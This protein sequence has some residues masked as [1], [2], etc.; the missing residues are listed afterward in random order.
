MI[1]NPTP[2]TPR[3]ARMIAALF[4]GMALF[5]AL[6]AAAADQ[7]PVRVQMTEEGPVFAT[8]SGMTL[9]SGYIDVGA[10]GRSKCNYTHYETQNGRIYGVFAL[11]AAKTRKTCADKW[12]PFLA[13][14]DAKAEGD[15]SVITRDGGARQ[16][17]YQGRPLYTSVKDHRPGEVNGEGSSLR[18]ITGWQAAKAPL[19]FPP[20]FKLVRRPEGLVLATAEGKPAYVR[21]GGRMQR[22][23]S[24]VPE[25]LQPI[26]APG[27]GSVGGKWSI[28]NSGAGTKQY[29][30]NGEALYVLPD[31]LTDDDIQGGG[32]APA[33]YRRAA[34]LPPQIRTR[35]TTVGNIYTAADGMSLYY[36]SCLETDSADFL[37]CNDPGDAAV[38]WSSLCGTPDE[39]S[40]RWRPYRAAANARPVGEWTI[41][42]VADPPFQDPAGVTSPAG[43]HKVKAWAYRGKPLYT[44]V[45]DD[46]PG[47]TLGHAIQNFGR[48]SF[49]AVG[50]P[51]DELD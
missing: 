20:G 4:A 5:G 42:D 48:S 49:N 22:T 43:S 6:G 26:A 34:P 3:P 23:A 31:G 32:W 30:F 45:D 8:S 28:V 33:V 10:P 27:F 36:F 25:M 44:F 51:G 39:C 1:R 35:V 17:A 50:V 7:P 47:E 37:T 14:A 29:A 9:Y 46:V 18:D 2:R 13:A 19:D 24:G 16:W 11:P 12:P 38:Y 41:E 15:W 40:R 21:R